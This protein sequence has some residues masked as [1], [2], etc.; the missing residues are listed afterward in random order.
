MDFTRT[1]ILKPSSMGDIVQAMP[2]LT[3]LAEGRPEAKAF[4]KT[5]IAEAMAMG[6]RHMTRFAK[7]VASRMR[8]ILGVPSASVRRG[9]G[10]AGEVPLLGR[11]GVA[12]GQVA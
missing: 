8:S 9:L 3:A 4:I 6:N 11:P 7:T 5:W 2:V 10:G 12:A 1:L